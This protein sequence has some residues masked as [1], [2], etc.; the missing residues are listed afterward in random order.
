MFV[1]SFPIRMSESFQEARTV[2]SAVTYFPHHV[3]FSLI[4]GITYVEEQ[5]RHWGEPLNM[6]HADGIREMTFS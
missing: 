6:N 1:S 5:S 4:L 3:A 2:A